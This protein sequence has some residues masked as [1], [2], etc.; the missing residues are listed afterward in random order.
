MSALKSTKRDPSSVAG[1][2]EQFDWVLT[3]TVRLGLQLGIAQDCREDGPN[4]TL[5][6]IARTGRISNVPRST[7]RTS[8]AGSRGEVPGQRQPISATPRVETRLGERVKES[9]SLLDA[10]F[11]LADLASGVRAP[12]RPPRS[13]WP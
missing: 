7:W 11:G 12:I 8:E 4:I 2:L 3:R 13:R 5:P 9:A 10:L 6:D 1:G